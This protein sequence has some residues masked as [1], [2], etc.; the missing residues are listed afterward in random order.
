MEHVRSRG[1]P[2]LPVP[3]HDLHGYS[4]S[5]S[6][7][8]SHAET[9]RVPVPLQAGHFSLLNSVSVVLRTWRSV[10]SIY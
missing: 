2:M 3:L 6:R 1:R 5:D 8:A 10:Y 9:A 7:R 4:W